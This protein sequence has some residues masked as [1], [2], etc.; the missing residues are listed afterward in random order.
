MVRF[1]SNGSYKSHEY[2]DV[3]YS[4]SQKPP[5]I[6]GTAERNDQFGAAVAMGDFNDDGFDDLANKFTLRG[7]PHTLGLRVSIDS[8]LGPRTGWSGDG[9]VLNDRAGP[10]RSPS[11]DASVICT[12]YQ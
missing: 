8:S 3:W 2:E 9:A 4:L 5:W 12:R 6:W 1:G 11:P 10:V 7:V